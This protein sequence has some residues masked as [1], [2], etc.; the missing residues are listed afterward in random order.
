MVV[1][2]AEEAS[3]TSEGAGGKEEEESD[4]GVRVRMYALYGRQ[5]YALQ[6]RLLFPSPSSLPCNR[7]NG[8]YCLHFYSC[9]D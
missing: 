3:R 7:T 2:A 5:A 8:N 6:M 4:A 9:V 1:T